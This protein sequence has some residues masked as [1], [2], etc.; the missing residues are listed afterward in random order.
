MEEPATQESTQPFLDPR[1]LGDR[2]DRAKD[3]ADII[4]TLHPTSPAAFK[5]VELVAEITPQHV[6]QNHNFSHKL[7]GIDNDP[8][9]CPGQDRASTGQP[10]TNPE[11]NDRL[12]ALAS[13]TSAQD[14]ALRISSHVKDI[15]LGWTFGRSPKYSDILIADGSQT[16]SISS[17]HFR[18]YLNDAGVLMLEDNSMNGTWVDDAFLCKKGHGKVFPTRRMIN[19]GSTIDVIT[20]NGQKDGIRFLVMM[21]RRDHWASRY[22]QKLSEYIGFVAQMKRQKEAAAKAA[23]DGNGLMMPPPVSH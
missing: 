1:R 22:A 18:I 6:L 2:S 3:E 13:G 20:V 14:I 16:S 5:A 15:C 9:L 8:G 4:C 17:V 19:P 10:R 23:T 7:E 21:P 12:P 11:A